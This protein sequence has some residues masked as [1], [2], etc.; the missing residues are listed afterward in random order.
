MKTIIITTVVMGVIIGGTVFKANTHEVN[1]VEA[2]VVELTTEQK[3]EEARNQMLK[4]IETLEAEK[5]A[6]EEKIKA[7]K[8]LIK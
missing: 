5:V 1:N 8:E 2:P 7:K 6:L 3:F 4:E